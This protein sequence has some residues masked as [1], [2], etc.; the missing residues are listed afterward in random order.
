MNIDWKKTTLPIAAYLHLSRGML[1]L[2]FLLA[3]LFLI[4]IN[5]LAFREVRGMITANRWV[6]HTHEVIQEVDTSLF[7]LVSIES[8]SRGFVLRG[9]GEILADVDRLKANLQASLHNLNA[10][11]AD[12]FEQNARVLRLQS[13]VDERLNYINRVMQIN[14]GSK[15]ENDQQILANSQA[16]SN[17]VQD[18]GH[19]IKAVELV[20]LKER[21]NALVETTIFT[22]RILVIGGSVGA[23]FLLAVFILANMELLARKKTEKFN[24]TIQWR[25]RKIIEST[26][27][28]IAAFDSD[29]RFIIFNEAYEWEFKRIFGVSI[30][31]GMLLTEAFS[32]I[33]AEKKAISQTWLENLAERFAKKEEFLVDQERNSYEMSASAILNEKNEIIGNVQTIRNI[34]KSVQEHLELQASYQRLA[35]G[36]QELQIKN[37]QI[38]LL[39]EMS[40]IML[41]CSSME[42][43]AEVMAKYSQRLL[44]F[45]GGYLFMMHPSK[46]YLEKSVCWGNPRAHEQTFTPD[47]CWAIRLGRVH[48]T[49]D[50][51]K[52]LV[53]SHIKID[54]HHPGLKL[55]CVPLMAQ[56]DIYGLLY[57][58]IDQDNEKNQPS[59]DENNKLLITAFAELT[60][61]SLA[62]VRLREN[63]R[64]QSIRDPLTGLYNRRYLEDFLFKQL[65]QAERTNVPFAVIMLDLDH[66]KRINDSY[67]HDAGDLVLKEFSHILQEDVRMGDLAA[68]FG[69][70]EFIVVLYGIDAEAALERAQ[71]IRKAV[72]KLQLKYGAQQI[73]SVTVSM[74]LAMYPADANSVD[75]LIEAADKALYQAKNK[76]RNRV[77]AFASMN[78][79]ENRPS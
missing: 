26:S 15:S 33:S 38:T 69:G 12:N 29:N 5:I 9:D 34:T 41:A 68:R 75:E 53:C 1:N 4:V 30:T 59:N 48:H 28:M 8:L 61:L 78:N 74:G 17:R 72:S 25:L 54:G 45:S 64:H 37:E 3:L 67:G 51:S 71:N 55:L 13:L 27:D 18:L 11:T 22:S 42:E 35:T 66:F 63:L 58:E 40:D 43:L 39:V 32:K 20:L 31:P 52:Q 2:I 60:A 46:N 65:H 76:G 56:N 49:K 6:I 7:T 21:N 23:L 14:M 36:M 73:G 16:I 10:L 57:L 70:E 47:Q 79:Q 19:E 44:Q 62:N 77:H 50:S 24:Q